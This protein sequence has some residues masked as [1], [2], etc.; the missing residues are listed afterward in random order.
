MS[1]QKDLPY[2]V[3]EKV[4]CYH[5]PLIYEAKILKAEYFESKNAS[6]GVTGQHYYIHYKGWKNTW[7]EWVE[8]SRILK[9]NDANLSKQKQIKEMYKSKK[10]STNVIMRKPTLDLTTTSTVSAATSNI[11][12][13]KKRKRELSI[14]GKE[15]STKRPMITLTVPEQLMAILVKDA[16]YIAKS[17]MLVPL[18]RKP[19]VIDITNQYIQYRRDGKGNQTLVE[20]IMEEVLRGLR[21]YFD[22]CLGA[23]LLYKIERSQ[24]KQMKI[25]HEDLSNCEIYGF[26]HLLRLF[27]QLPAIISQANL[28]SDVSGSL[29][30]Y[31][32]DF[33]N[34]LKENVKEY[35]TV[36][37]RKIE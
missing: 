19:S 12:K 31:I 29:K 5:G 6:S 20:G 30:L 14:E 23:R 16:T 7:D 21:L 9:Y 28:G 33:L 10:S 2:Q 8:E 36:D 24:Y 32:D 22:K 15:D 18:P 13:G 37:Y 35:Y 17:Q 4:L 1:Q 25:Q 11:E 26:E 27:V 34:F 3:S